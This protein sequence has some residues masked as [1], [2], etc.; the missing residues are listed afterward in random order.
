MGA[1]TLLY[2]HA[3]KIEDFEI[4]SIRP[5]DDSLFSA[6]KAKAARDK[7]CT[8]QNAIFIAVG[9][10]LAKLCVHNMPALRARVRASCTMS[11]KELAAE[12]LV[13]I[14]GDGKKR[15]LGSS[16]DAGSR[17]WAFMLFHERKFW[18]MLYRMIAASV[19]LTQEVD[20]DVI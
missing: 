3:I 12:K 17:M 11:T 4:A 13:S 7:L 8:C 16:L 19:L 6:A 18:Q 20:N 10:H 1:Y 2:L 15:R 9:S 14:V 5:C